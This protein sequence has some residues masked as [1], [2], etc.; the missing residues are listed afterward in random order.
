M[1]TATASVSLLNTPD[2]ELKSYGE[3][4]D[5]Q[6]EGK[7]ETYRRSLNLIYRFQDQKW[8]I[9]VTFKGAIH[10]YPHDVKP[11]QIKSKRERRKEFQD[12][13]KLID[14]QLLPLL[15]DTVTEVI[16]NED[17]ET[18]EHIKLYREPED[19]NPFT[20]LTRH[21]RF[22]IREDPSRVI[23]PLRQQFPSFRAI[24]L[25]ELVEEDEISDGVFR[26]LHRSDKI[27]YILKVVSRPLYLPHDSDVIRKELENLERFKG[28]PGVVQS[29]GIAVFSNPYATSQNSLEQMVISGI[30]LEYHKGGSLQRV[31][32]KHRVQ[33]FG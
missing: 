20:K 17:P 1:A 22:Y 9:K 3:D 28:V 13:V 8:W 2:L 29:A 30:L 10:I 15:D 14:F 23:Y 12:F 18:N 4:N 31:I 7:P 11:E 33:E 21:L 32:N 16:L 5:Y 25:A 26:V 27:P 6:A 24:D 19:T